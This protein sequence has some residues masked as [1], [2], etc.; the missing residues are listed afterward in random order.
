MGQACAGST[1]QTLMQFLPSSTMLPIVT[2][3]CSAGNS[4]YCLSY[5]A[6]ADLHAV[7]P[8]PT[9][10][11]TP[12]A[13]HQSQGRHSGC[14]RGR[15][16]RAVTCICISSR[17]VPVRRGFPV[18]CTIGQPFL[19]I[20]YYN[21]CKSQGGCQQLPVHVCTHPPSGQS[22][23]A[24]LLS[25]QSHLNSHDNGCKHTAPSH[26]TIPCV[27]KSRA[28]G[29]RTTEINE[30]RNCCQTQ[31]RSLCINPQHMY[32]YGSSQKCW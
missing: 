19:S 23:H 4:T 7:Q 11:A 30:W 6:G 24:P 9:W 2:A 25:T 10:V 29:P 21:S 31:Q 18:C 13:Q 28:Q 27:R 22:S 20:V 3:A 32:E 12:R 14:G 16:N 5:C 15:P 1:S 8:P 17:R 26:V